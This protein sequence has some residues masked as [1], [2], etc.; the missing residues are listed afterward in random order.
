MGEIST[1]GKAIAYYRERKRWTRGQ[2][3][4][5]SGVTASYISKMEKGHLRGNARW[6]TLEKLAKPLEVTVEDLTGFDPKELKEEKAPYHVGTSDR[7]ERLAQ[8]L[9]ALSD[10]E[11]E[12]LEL[13]VE[14]LLRRGTPESG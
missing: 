9:G 4:T 14:R 8:K 10:D 5:Y 6:S 12:G 1:I 7:A 3:A 11:L 13:L 2:L